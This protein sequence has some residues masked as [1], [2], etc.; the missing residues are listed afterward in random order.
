MRRAWLTRLAAVTEPVLEQHCQETLADEGYARLC[1]SD[2]AEVLD[3][4]VW[5]LDAFTRCLEDGR[6]FDAEE[7]E[8][9]RK[10]GA[11]RAR[12]GVSIGGLKARFRGGVSLCTAELAAVAFAETA[13][14]TGELLTELILRD[15]LPLVDI[16][17]DA[18][19]DGHAE[20]SGQPCHSGDGAVCL[21]EQELRVLRL[22]PGHTNS[23]IAVSLCSSPETVKTQVSSVLRKLDARD[24]SHAVAIGM[25]QGLFPVQL[26]ASSGEVDS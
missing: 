24:R 25:T 12:Q 7:L 17:E 8:R 11:D 13:P 18:L 21:S 1:G 19:V 4:A 10:I 9:F 16:A 2:A 15:L 5:I 14:L 20:V 22:L 23:Q 6:S 26:P 3:A